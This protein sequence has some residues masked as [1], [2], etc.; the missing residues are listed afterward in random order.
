MDPILAGII[1]TLAVILIIAIV[2]I[3]VA[4]SALTDTDSEHRAAVLSAVAEILRAMRG[5]K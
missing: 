5:K 3:V 1:T 4:R 2:T